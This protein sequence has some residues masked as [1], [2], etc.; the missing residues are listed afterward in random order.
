M[1]APLDFWYR[2]SRGRRIAFLTLV[3]AILGGLILW[4][5][6]SAVSEKERVKA[7]V[8]EAIRAAEDESPE[9]LAQVF[10]LQYRGYY[11]ENRGEL[12]RLAERDFRRISD[13]DIDVE[14]WTIEIEGD[15][16][17]VHLRFKFRLKYTRGPYRNVPITR[18]SPSSRG[19]DN[20]A[21]LVLQLEGD[22]WRIVQLEASI[23]PH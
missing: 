9:I 8:L 6:Q 12:L 3:L 7:A 5:A 17:R 15:R 22:S 21:D 23:P 10:S 18:L 2:L 4:L 19:D 14:D 20:Q 11:G 1:S 13:L 16:A